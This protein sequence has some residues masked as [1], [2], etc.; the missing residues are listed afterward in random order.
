MRFTSNSISKCIVALLLAGLMSCMLCASAENLIRNPEFEEDLSSGGITFWDCDLWDGT[1]DITFDTEKLGIYNCLHILSY[2]DNDARWIQTVDVKPDTEYRLSGY[3]LAQGCSEEDTARGANLSIY[4]SSAY[5]VSVYDTAGE[6]QYVEIYGKTGSGQTELTVCARIGGFSGI[7]SGEAWFRDIELEEDEAPTQAMLQSFSTYAPSGA[8]SEGSV[9][10]SLSG[11][12]GSELPERRTLFWIAVDV[13]F[14]ILF[15]QAYAIAVHIIKKRACGPWKHKALALTGEACALVLLFA[16]AGAIRVYFAFRVRGYKNDIDC[17][18]YWGNLF[19]EQGFK[20]YANAS[21]HDYPPL[22][23]MLLGS[24]DALRETV[25]IGYA[26]EAHVALIK[27]IPILSDLVTAGFVYGLFRKNS[28]PFASILAS[29]LI[30]LNP[31]YI[32]DS[33]AW[34]QVDSLLALLLLLT[35]Y[36]GWKGRWYLALPIYALAVLTKPQALMF[37]PIGLIAVVADV[38]RTPRRIP[39]ALIGLGCSLALLAVICL[40]FAH[41]ELPWTQEYSVSK[42]LKEAQTQDADGY[43][44]QRET[45][46]AWYDTVLGNDPQDR[47][48]SEE[49][50]TDPAYRDDFIELQKTA[51]FTAEYYL[52]QGKLR[53][54]NAGSLFDAAEEALR[55]R[56]GSDVVLYRYYSAERLQRW[57]HISSEYRQAIDEGHELTDSEWLFMEICDSILCVPGLTQVLESEPVPSRP[58]YLLTW[59]WNKLMGTAQSYQYMTVNA[60]NLYVIL[61]K[62]WGRMDDPF[63]PDRMRHF[64]W[65]MMGL[66]Y[67]YSGIILIGRKKAAL[68]TQDSSN[69]SSPG[70]S[71]SLA[72]AVLLSLLFSFAPMMHERYL[73][74]AIAFVLL[75]YVQHRDRRLLWYCA[76]ISATQFLNIALVLEWGGISGMGHLQDSEK[77]I[78][79]V[80]SALN[81]AAALF[82]CWTAFDLSLGWK[83]RKPS[84]RTD[85]RLHLKRFDFGVMALVTA[86]Y[87]VLAFV[88]LGETD[89]PVT[90]YTTQMKNEQIVFDLGEIKTYRLTYYGGISSNYFTVALSNDGESWTEENAA[91]YGEGDIYKWIWYV[92]K[93]Y[94]GGSFSSAGY[95]RERAADTGEGGAEVTYASGADAWPLQT[96]RYVRFTVADEKYYTPVATQKMVL[97]EVAFLDGE[98]GMPLP[99]ASVRGSVSEAD[100]SPL[101]DEQDKVPAY[102]SY[103]NG[104]YFDEIYHAR[105]G[106]ELLNGYESN[107]IL[108][109]S[110]PH[111]GKLLIALGIK[112]FGMT[113]FGWRFSGALVG[114]LML[115]VMYLLIR[116]ISGRSS[117]ALLGMLLL[118]LDSMHFTQTRIATVDSYA[119]FFIMLM[120]LFMIRYFKMNLFKVKFWR[121]LITLLLSGLFMGLACASKWI[122][123][124]AALGLALIFFIKMFMTLREYLKLK[125]KDSGDGRAIAGYPVRQMLTVDLCCVAFILVPAAIYYFSYY[126]HFAASGG[127]SAAKVWQLQ[128]QMYSYHANIVDTHYFNTPWYEWPI[129]VWPMWYFSSDTAFT[130]RGT[131]SSISLMG[132]PAVWWTGIL[133][134]VAVTGIYLMQKKKDHR[135]L[136][137]IIGFA[138]QYLPWVLVPRSTYIYHYFASVPFIIAATALCIEYLESRYPRAARSLRIVLVAAALILFVMFYPLE[139]GM[140]VSYRYAKI[141]RWFDWYNFAP[142]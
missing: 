35:V 105:T 20:F 69:P 31:A 22:Y 5:S 30:A 127:L 70:R 126:W 52:L 67:L 50:I 134:L 116:Q 57:Q 26:S 122:G 113:P 119:V 96:S 108:E 72:G 92:P 131:V 120:Y 54:D 82:L 135:L 94:S 56:H 46:L 18:L 142:Q 141:L 138:S 86:L 25:G 65:I 10:G 11:S 77:V 8:Q 133:C 71:L 9:S 123:A 95:S 29:A 49:G 125:R 61:G 58:V 16:A 62:N 4:N 98:T 68:R 85:H 103:Y 132:N 64:A 75:A 15:V 90:S 13:L 47:H 6:W 36:F 55:R 76:W 100:Y 80:V 110:H 111:M 87:A 112:L 99:V 27:L 91:S 40:P 88:N 107:H 137:V 74:P 1:A 37:G 117:S 39:S 24:I 12:D 79:T 121:Q 44:E 17:F 14:V 43:N 93:T 104:F 59:L 136:L 51:V 78:N 124:Y 66:S 73:F 89:S 34:G 139:S 83:L 7:G 118:A 33:A 140:P 84:S 81:I 38:C 128:Q 23:M 3:I 41:Y 101:I 60:C 114:V 45:Y 106:Y 2:E 63:K 102:P 42:Y 48:L 97:N 21:F 130:G 19:K 129:I 115:P 53:P 109:W 28:R 32:A